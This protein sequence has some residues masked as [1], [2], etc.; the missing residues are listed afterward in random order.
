MSADDYDCYD[1]HLLNKGYLNL[2][3]KEMI[4]LSYCAI[5][6]EKNSSFEICKFFGNSCQEFNNALFLRIPE[7]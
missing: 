7:R 5:W 4:L 3:C 1:C 2:Q 6:G